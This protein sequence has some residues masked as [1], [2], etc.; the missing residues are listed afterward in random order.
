MAAIMARVE[1]IIDI[2]LDY[3]VWTLLHCRRPATS[4]NART[5]ARGAIVSPA[6]IPT[7]RKS[8]A[9]SSILSG[10]LLASQR[11]APAKATAGRAQRWLEPESLLCR[12]ET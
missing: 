2:D 9:D 11:Q 10:G 1:K 5:G 6:L 12:P 4:P 3:F 7:L 8:C